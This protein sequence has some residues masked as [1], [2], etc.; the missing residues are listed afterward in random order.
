MRNK[1]LKKRISN[2]DEVIASRFL[3]SLLMGDVVHEPNGNIPPDFRV[4][5][6]IGVEVRRLNQN[7]LLPNGKKEGFESIGASSWLSMVR[8]LKEFG[9]S[10]DGECWNVLIEFRHPLDWRAIKSDIAAR[11][12]EFK[13]SIVRSDVNF[14]FGSNFEVILY[15]SRSDKRDFFHLMGSVPT[16]AGGAVMD[17]VEK[18]LRLCIE[19]KERKVAPY[20]ERYE[21]WWLVLVNR[22]D[23][24]M[25]SEDYVDFRKRIN[26]AI[27]H[28]FDRIFFVDWANHLHWFE[29]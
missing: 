15:R 29:L 19:E 9:P 16:D 11:L 13:S 1:T 25:Q 5:G 10:V 12:H 2:R 3:N 6:R 22:V 14:K 8:L 17:L 27:E 7:Y 4:A 20:R 18:N 21:E 23:L 28:T 24:Y 26:P